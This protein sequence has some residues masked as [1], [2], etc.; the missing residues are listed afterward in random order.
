MH[1]R[2]LRCLLAA[3]ALS[4]LWPAHAEPAAQCQLPAA[5]SD[6]LPDRAGL[7]AQYERLPPACLQEI[8]RGCSEAASHGV[9]DFSTA[10][11]CSF[12]YEALLRQQF[13]GD[14]PALMAWWRP[15]QEPSLQ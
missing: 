8:F 11:V 15:Q 7:L 4:A 9:L 3:A 6:A 5:P 12:G 10:A 13:G 2:A 1:A 14:F